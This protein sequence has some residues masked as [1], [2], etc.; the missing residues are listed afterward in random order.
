MNRNGCYTM[1]T[2]PTAIVSINWNGGKPFVVRT[3]KENGVRVYKNTYDITSENDIVLRYQYIIRKNSDDDYKV[4]LLSYN[5]IEPTDSMINSVFEHFDGEE[6]VYQAKTFKR[7]WLGV[8]PDN[9]SFFGNTVLIDLTSYNYVY[10][11]CT[12]EAFN[13][14]NRITAFWAPV[15]NSNVPY[16][17]AWSTTD[18]YSLVEMTRYNRHVIKLKVGKSNVT[19]LAYPPTKYGSHSSKVVTQLI[20]DELYH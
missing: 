6:P 12:I 3:D 11:S 2:L 7:I 1:K 9:D 14:S 13:L 4:G 19:K 16:P 17:I 15:G 5:K 8:D 10:V 18:V 20:C